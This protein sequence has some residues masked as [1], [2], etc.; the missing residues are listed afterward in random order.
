AGQRVICELAVDSCFDCEFCDAGH[1]E[2]CMKKRP[3]GW[4]SQGVYTERINMPKHCV[5]P[6][7][8]AVSYEV[9]ALAEP[10]A[11]C[12][13][14]ILERAQIT[15]KEFTVIYGM[16]PIGLLSLLVLQDLGMENII[17]VTP[18]HRGSQRLELAKDLGCEH[19]YS[20]DENIPEI[21]EKLSNGKMA[22]CVVDCSGAASAINEGIGLL[23]KGGK[24]VALGIAGQEEIGI[25]FN[26]ALLKALH[27]VFSCTSSHNAWKI[28]SGILE[29]QHDKIAKV[30]THNYPLGQWREAYDKIENREAI[31]AV[32]VPDA[33]K[34]S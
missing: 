4:A 34:E 29:R 17:C 19:V 8:D 31:K 5:I 16:G 22:D 2:F 20:S 7:A 3:P 14:G 25:Q 24:L 30:I 21:I 10:I 33:V 15:G 27:I 13:Y 18:T 9:A 11:I 32:L 1:Y 26:K 28:T 6:V 23:K 12:V